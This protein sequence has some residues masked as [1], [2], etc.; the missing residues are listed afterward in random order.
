MRNKVDFEG[1]I[2]H[3]DELLGLDERA[4]LHLYGRKTAER[5]RAVERPIHVMGGDGFSVVELGVFANLEGDGREQA[6]AI[7][8]T[9]LTPV[10][11]LK[12]VAP[13]HRVFGKVLPELGAAAGRYIE[14]PSRWCRPAGRTPLRLRR[15]TRN[16]Y[17]PGVRL[18][19]AYRNARAPLCGEGRPVMMLAHR[20]IRIAHLSTHCPL[21]V[22]PAAR[23]EKENRVR[24]ARSGRRPAPA[25][26]QATQN[27][28][29]GLESPCGRGR[30]VRKRG[31]GG[32]SRLRSQI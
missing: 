4:R 7:P 22:G 2:I 15:S 20:K 23:Q 1:G 31:N 16:P 28:H 5:N 21:S 3:D 30:L 14:K 32:N 9:A 26:S 29:R 10:I 8:G 24:G 18:S 27:R 11:D 25:G 13:E 19:R 17:K 6:P 12:N